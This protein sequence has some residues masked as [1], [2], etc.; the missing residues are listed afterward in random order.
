MDT[1]LGLIRIV[2]ARSPDDDDTIVLSG[3]RTDGDVV[4]V[5]KLDGGKP[6]FCA[7]VLLML[8]DRGFAVE[9]ESPSTDTAEPD[10]RSAGV[11]TS[12][13]RDGMEW[14]DVEA[15]FVDGQ[16]GA[17]ASF[18]PGFETFAWA[19]AATCCRQGG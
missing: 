6:A 10:V 7:G 2:A 9:G 12:I 8:E 13:G 4:T 15:R 14:T 18:A 3:V 11:R 16:K 17:V 1:R 19:T 5:A